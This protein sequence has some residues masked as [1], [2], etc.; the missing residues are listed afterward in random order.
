MRTP[1]AGRSEPLGLDPVEA[2]RE[3]LLP[4]LLEAR[5]QKPDPH[6]AYEERAGYVDGVLPGEPDYVLLEE[7]L[8]G[9]ECC[10]GMVAELLQSRHT[11]PHRARAFLERFERFQRL[12]AAGAATEDLVRA[13]LREHGGKL[14]YEREGVLIQ[15]LPDGSTRPLAAASMASEYPEHPGR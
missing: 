13:R 6:L 11:A 4:D 7:H 14:T 3:R 8:W 12:S 1:T 2:S 10:R 15:E 9:C 5:R